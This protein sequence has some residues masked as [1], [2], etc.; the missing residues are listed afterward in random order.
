MAAAV[1]IIH[2]LTAVMSIS[3]AL[4]LAAVQPNVS[5]RTRLEVAGAVVLGCALSHFWPY[6]SPWVVVRGGHGQD[7]DW[8][9][10]SVKQ[11]AALQVKR[12]LHEFYQPRGL[13]SSLGL[14]LLPLAVFPWFLV[15]RERWFVALGALSMGLPFVANAFVELPLGHRFV[16]LAMVY[17][18]I[19]VVWLLLLFTR[20]SSGPFR[21][22]Q[23]RWLGAVTSFGVA[24]LL[25]FF[26]AHSVL[27]ARDVQ[28]SPRFYS[29]PE[30]YVISNMR[31][32]VALTGPDAV[33]LANP[34][35]SWP[36]PTF[37][38]KV[39]ALYHEDP[40]V[41][42]ASRRELAVRRFLGPGDKDEDRRQILERY[43]VSHVLLDHREGGAVL[44]FLAKISKVRSV[45]T[46]YRLYTLEPAAR[47]SAAE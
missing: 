46:G 10:E 42:D 40:L 12:R 26:F 15:K 35:L 4:L 3:G 39:L 38:P 31:A 28:R 7:A 36:L 22:V 19:G 33:V 8:A 20:A 16:L 1:F 11:A 2:Q 29:R 43:H 41:P 6:F 21:F 34:L 14:C 44:R 37:G 13:L 24:A 17:L 45:G 5:W 25:L 23:R 27:L 32:I 9:A 30:S 47:K 18:H